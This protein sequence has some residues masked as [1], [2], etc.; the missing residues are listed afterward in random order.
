MIEVIFFDFD[1]VLVESVDIK[2]E[3]LARLFQPEG[4]EVV[5]AA[6]NYHLQNTG[7]PRFDKFRYIYREIL[8]KPLVDAEFRRLS[9]SFAEI[10][11]D[12][13]VRAP[14]VD[15]ALQ[16]LREHAVKYRCYVTS[17]TPQEEMRRI[18]NTRNMNQFFRGVYGAP[19]TKKDAVRMTLDKEGV[20]P[21]QAL[22]VGDALSDY[23][24]ASE[25]GVPFVARI[26]GNEQLFASINCPKIKDLTALS[27]VLD[28]L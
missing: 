24:A 12:A 11:V 8:K 26:A 21:S 9:D 15:G 4:P 14:Y 20:K 3:A 7:M 27:T 5:K 2:T 10:V 19:T 16:F 25:N 17:A 18:I 22:Y 13:V 28:T 6:V 23:R 1:G